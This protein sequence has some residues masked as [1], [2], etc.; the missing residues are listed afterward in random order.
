M[1]MLFRL[2]DKVVYI[3]EVDSTS[4]LWAYLDEE[5]VFTGPSLQNNH[6]SN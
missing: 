5:M 1:W 2:S 6:H 4:L 3:E